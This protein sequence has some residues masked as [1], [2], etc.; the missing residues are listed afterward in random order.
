VGSIVVGVDSSDGA[1]R[2]LEWAVAE[3]RHHGSKVVAVHTWNVPIAPVGPGVAAV[4]FN[5]DDFKNAGQQAF[6][7]A[8]QGVSTEGVEVEQRLVEGSPANALMDTAREERADLLVV[9][10]R[11]H[12]GFT[13]MLLGSVS[14][15]LAHH[16]PVP[17]VIVPPADRD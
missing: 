6:D 15:A 17:L 16:S 13:G 11:G 9:G 14:S 7:A 3:A 2:A 1:R 8:M 5:T 10:T 4:S 12:G